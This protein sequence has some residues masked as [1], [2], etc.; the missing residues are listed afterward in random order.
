MNRL[1]A[2]FFNKSFIYNLFKIAD[3]SSQS[4]V[5]AEDLTPLILH[6]FLNF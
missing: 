4:A 3:F 2:F 6:F 1:M 5:K